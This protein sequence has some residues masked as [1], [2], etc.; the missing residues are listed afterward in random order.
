MRLGIIGTG[1]MG[2]L[3]AAHLAP[4]AD[5]TVLGT[6]REGV[7]ALQTGGVRLEHDEGMTRIPVCAVGSPQDCKPVDAA[8][9][10]VKGHQTRRAAEW[11]RQILKPNGIAVTLQNGLGNLELIAEEVGAQRA[12]IGV[13]M[14]G[15]TLIAPGLVR[16][17]GKGPTTLAYT[18]ETRAKLQELAALMNRAG[19]ETELT[20]DV[21]GLLWGKLVVNSAINALTAVLQV[22]NGWLVENADARAL[23]AAAAQETANV[24]HA[25][26]VALPYP[27]AAERALAVA[28]ATAAN[29]SSTLQDVL[30]G[31]PTELERINGAVIREGRRVGVPTPVNETLMRL[32]RAH[33]ATHTMQIPMRQRTATLAAIQ[34]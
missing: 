13:S 26:G 30:R 19:I 33:Q 34:I 16:H 20:Q 5:V 15:A 32:F 10:V 2:S 9:V 8:L 25:L 6:W 23:V 21:R 7:Q 4:H 17:A 29:R 11:A 28:T 31:A 14:Q 3:L 1:A 18:P 27:D 24:A 22:P 12:A